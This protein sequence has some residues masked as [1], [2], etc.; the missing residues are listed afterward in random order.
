MTDA[1]ERGLRRVL[2]QANRAIRAGRPPLPA[3]TNVAMRGYLA[4][5][6]ARREQVR[7]YQ[8][9]F[10]TR[11][12]TFDR[13]GQCSMCNYGIGPE[14]DPGRI[15]RA[16]RRRLAG[17]PE[18]ASVYL[19]P[20]G[21]LLDDVEVP[22]EL[23][24]QLLREVAARRP[25]MFAFESRPEVFTARKLAHLR[26]M[27]P[28]TSIIGQVGAESWDPEVRDL[29]HLKPTP[30]KAYLAAAAL[31]RDNGFAS[32]ANITLGAC[33]LSQREAYED[34]LSSVRGARQAGYHTQMVFPLSAK[35]GTL[36]AWAA[37]RGLWTP[38]S[39]W[40]LVY[41]LAE[42]A[43]DEDDVSGVSISWFDTELNDVV[44]LRPDACAACR[45]FLLDVLNEFR[46]TPRSQSL[47]RAFEWQGCDC[48]QRARADL[49]PDPDDPG[50]LSRLRRLAK[51]WQDNQATAPEG[52]RLL[53][54]A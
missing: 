17:V 31:L 22:F 24:E 25:R 39:L 47:A 54:Q 12:C 27:L 46:A 33:G 15:V 19:S 7:M 49:A 21:S 38:P 20:S 14:V 29:C 9:W 48:P 45:P 42:A 13:A 18:G 32:I 52:H 34:T 41:V 5:T 30:Q 1:G 51:L 10:R 36:L 16:L 8:I 44:K 2:V 53:P 28:S 26:E 40:T 3:H 6:G 11:G 43:A 4:A 35:A 37:D 50:Y 23:R